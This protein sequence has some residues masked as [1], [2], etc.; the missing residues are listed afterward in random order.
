VTPGPVLAEVLP[1]AG[2]GVV[3]WVRSQDLR[4]DAWN[5]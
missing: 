5:L 2:I 1:L 4:F 3:T